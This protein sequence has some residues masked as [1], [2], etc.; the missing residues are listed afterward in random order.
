M[1]LKNLDLIAGEMKKMICK[2][3]DISLIVIG[4]GLAAYGISQLGLNYFLIGVGCGLIC[5]GRGAK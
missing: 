4:A 3:L 5:L 2:W 1:S